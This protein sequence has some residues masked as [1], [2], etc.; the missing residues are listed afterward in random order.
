MLKCTAGSSYILL[1]PNG[2]V[3]RCMRNYNTLEKPMYNLREKNYK[4]LLNNS[5]K[6]CNQIICNTSCDLDWSSKF[7]FKKN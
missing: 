4:I 3:Y 5:A 2:D 1:Y 6:E 7:V